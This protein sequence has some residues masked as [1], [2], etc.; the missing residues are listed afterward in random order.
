MEFSQVIEQRRSIRHYDASKKVTQAQVEEMVEAAILAPSWK[1]SQTARYYAILSEDKIEDF[2][3]KCLPE[4]NANNSKG[5]ALIVTTFVANRAGFN[6]EGQ[7][8]NEAGN[9]WGFYDLGLHNE[10]LVLKAKDMGLDTL[11]MGIRDEKAIR[12]FLQV[13]EAE[14][15]VA[16]IAVGYASQGADM[17][18]RKT[19]A[20]ILKIC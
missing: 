10:N 15:I 12:Q 8:D 2:L 4:F 17:P 13:P 19:P 14:T 3:A 9:G 1:N 7:P 18:K 16:V 5:A 11:I 20:D 6:R